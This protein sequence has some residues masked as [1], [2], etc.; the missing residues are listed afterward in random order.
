MTDTIEA[1]DHA[2]RPYRYSA[3]LA[4]QIERIWQKRWQREG[5]FHAPNPAGPLAGSTDS[6][7]LYVLDMFP[8]P[9]GRG[10]H[11]GHPL[12]Y[13]GTD[14]YARFKRMTGHNVLHA[15]GFDA[16][17]LPA[18]QYAVR[19]GQHPRV[20]TEDNIA[21]M[22]RQLSRLG[23]GHDERRSVATTD[24]SFYRWTQWIF[25]QI[26]GSWYDEEQDR[27]RPIAELVAEFEAG[28]R[29]PVAPDGSGPCSWHG[30]SEVARR[31]VVD[32]YRLA[33]LDEAPINWCPGL[34]TVLA[35]EEVTPDGRSELGNF[36]VYRRPLRQWMMRITAYAD[37]LIADL[38]RVDWPE[39][40]KLMQRNWIGRSQGARIWFVT[41]GGGERIEV[42][43]T[44]PDTLFGATYLVLAPEHPLVDA[45]AAEQWPEHTPRAWT[46]HAATPAEAVADYRTQAGAKSDVERQAESREKTG[47][48]IGAS[49]INPANGRAVPIFIADYVLMGYGT[50]AIMAVPGGDTRDFAF[51][52]AFGID[53]VKVVDPP[54]AWF[55]QHSIDPDTACVDWPD[56]YTGEGTGVNS[57]NAGVSL[58][59]LPTP[60]AKQRIITWL[61]QA[62]AGQGAVTF[63]LR[64]WLFSRQ[65]YW[66]EP[67]PIV[68]DEHDLP[69]A[70][71]E[72]MLPVELPEVD[73]YAPRIVGD[74]EA[75][76]EPPL[77]RAQD[78]V[79]VELDL[80]EGPKTYRRETNTMPQWAGSCWYYLRYLDPTNDQA[81]VDPAVERYW[82]GDGATRAG[83]V[84][85]YVGG[86][87]HAVLHL[88]YARFW[89]K[90]LYDLGHV[91]QPEPF[92]RLFNQ[93]YIQ[94]AA[95]QDERGFYVE[96]SEV[97][98]T[99]EGFFHQGRPVTQQ[100]GKMGKSLRNSVTPDEM[101]AEYG[102]DT[103]RLYEMY[104]GPLDAS[105]PWESRAIV[106]LYRFLQRVWRLLV[107]E[108]TGESRVSDE[109]LDEESR[110]MLHRTIDAVRS[111][112]DQLRF[113]TSI[114]RLIELN[115]RLTQ[116]YAG[117]R[118]P[119]EAA[120]PLLLM[121]APLAPHVA[122]ELWQRI[123]HEQSLAREPFPVADPDLVK[124][125]RVTIVVQ[126]DGKVRASTEVDAAADAGEMERAARA[127]ERIARLLAGRE[128]R[129]VI[130]VP[131]RLV[132]FV[133][134]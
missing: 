40:V 69:R 5:T 117:R 98:Q 14:V 102:A 13:I 74:D 72:S 87:E 78:W 12:G 95:Y 39:P 134:D 124:Q 18:E 47:V 109:A 42:F 41:R 129:R 17:G 122:E 35:N 58:D 32:G 66:G 61:E 43:T 79:H 112:M 16:F 29:T 10:L 128:V 20:T 94:A 131:G 33:Y 104:T 71:P 59:G 85:L 113:N 76:P 114:A 65:R 19:T 64:D 105:R 67:F 80:G 2:T 84:D 15:M 36:P 99:P 44:R 73:D 1:T 130:T 26:F 30:L 83:G 34:G 49:A 82:M 45:L 38:E 77:S 8:Y 4:G 127:Q 96:A 51:A 118:L 81:M 70:L 107:D 60:E 115:N 119:V 120:E 101:Y 21:N 63:K 56:A 11:V 121:L 126:I 92:Q 133:T 54:Q 28:R 3:A 6:P 25:L 75:V 53:I 111:G 125:E 106:G 37:R 22:R 9:S 68:F 86:V 132:N 90:V 50:G 123:G 97:V 23:L 31:R 93:G 116:V 7:S 48:F 57:A 91:S 46:G 108:D 88:L 62:A 89:H 55:D 110:R 52:K 103:L 27:A 100:W 24:V